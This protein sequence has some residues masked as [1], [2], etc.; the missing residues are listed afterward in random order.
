LHKSL[1]AIPRHPRRRRRTTTTSNIISPVLLHH[2]KRVIRTLHLY[3]LNETSTENSRSN[4]VLALYYFFPRDSDF[5]LINL[6]LTNLLVCL[7]WGLINSQTER[8]LTVL[9][10]FLVLVLLVLILNNRSGRNE[11]D[12]EEEE[13]EED[14]E[15]LKIATIIFARAIVI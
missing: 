6:A 10:N 13:E 14:K 5:F 8:T 1:R 7:L 3:F 2:I 12:D 4:T 15:Q 11:H 9:G